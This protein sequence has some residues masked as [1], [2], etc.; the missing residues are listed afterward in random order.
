MD[1][2]HIIA[3]PQKY[4]SDLTANRSGVI[5]F[6]KAGRRFLRDS[7]GPAIAS[8]IV[9][10]GSDT[11]LT[12][13]HS[14]RS[15]IVV[16][17][18]D[19]LPL[20]VAHGLTHEEVEKIRSWPTEVLRDVILETDEA[21][22]SNE[23]ERKPSAIEKKLLEMSASQLL[24]WAHSGSSAEQFKEAPP[25]HLEN[26][27]AKVVHTPAGNRLPCFGRGA[28]IVLIDY[29]LNIEHP[30]LLG[31]Q[32]K[33]YVEF[34]PDNRAPVRRTVPKQDRRDL[35]GRGGHGTF[36]ASLMVSDKLGLAP[37]AALVV[38]ALRPIEGTVSSIRLTQLLSALQW[39]CEYI[40]RNDCIRDTAAVNM[41]LE[42]VRGDSITER[43]LE[44]LRQAQRT[45]PVA[46]S[47]NNG[48]LAFP[49]AAPHVLS[50]GAIDCNDLVW[51]SSGRNDAEPR[52]YAPGVDVVGATSDGKVELRSGT[53]FSAALVS[54][55]AALCVSAQRHLGD[56]PEQLQS[57]ILSDALSAQKPFGARA[58]DL[59]QFWA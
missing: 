6:R 9:F 58:L 59:R 39:T 47:G 36:V 7:L 21:K 29:G 23:V 33:E 31:A 32:I 49:G 51:P 17:D 56:D 41:S 4:T 57:R 22:R 50:V 12:P 35:H 38:A 19:H 45:L 43:Y 53:S 25:W 30:L 8:R 55:A 18:H 15:R 16:R 26:I 3:I 28:Q 2:P 24:D 54:A 10:L 27:G 46:A 11:T 13:A 37:E 40:D 42:F 52:I 14:K 20:V 1:S 44:I 48:R 34:P 5:N